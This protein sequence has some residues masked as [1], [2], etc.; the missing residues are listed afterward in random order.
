MP[1]IDEGAQPKEGS[2]YSFSISSVAPKIAALEIGQTAYMG[3]TAAYARSV[4]YGN[5]SFPGYG[6]VRLAAQNWQKHVAD[7]V[8]EVRNATKAAVR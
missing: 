1:A 5:G 2:S 7:A 4:E 8:R 3:F 6:F